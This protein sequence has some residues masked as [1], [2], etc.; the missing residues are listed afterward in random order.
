MLSQELS[1]AA[2]LLS[3]FGPN[4]E[5]W[6]DRQSKDELWRQMEESVFAAFGA[7]AEAKNSLAALHF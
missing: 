7:G 4:P 3:H 6:I 5:S 2:A 1:K